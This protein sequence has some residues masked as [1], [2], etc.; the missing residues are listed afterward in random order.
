MTNRIIQIKKIQT[1]KTIQTIQIIQV[2]QTMKLQILLK[3]SK[4]LTELLR[5]K[6][7]ILIWIQK[8]I[9]HQLGKNKLD[10]KRKGFKEEE[11]LRI[12]HQVNIE[13]MEIKNQNQSL[14]KKEFK[15]KMI[16]EILVVAVL[17]I[18]IE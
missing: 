12:I 17:K 16:D 2:I 9:L 8:V 4:I 13:E 3:S 6:M 15:E 7:V 5:T 18:Q 10:V 14:N 1:L 11:K